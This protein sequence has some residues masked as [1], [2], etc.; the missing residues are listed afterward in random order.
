MREECNCGQ[1]P[2]YPGWL[3]IFRNIPFNPQPVKETAFLPSLTTD[4]RNEEAAVP[5]GSVEPPKEVCSNVSSNEQPSCS[6]ARPMVNS[7]ADSEPMFQPPAIINY[8]Q[9]TSLDTE[10]LQEFL[11][12]N[13]QYIVITN[14]PPD[15]LLRPNND[16]RRN[17]VQCI[18]SNNRRTLRCL[19]V[20]LN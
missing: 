10:Q 1:Y 20:S 19:P 7:A 14:K 8:M 16:D 13:G 11:G 15:D 5:S 2:H 3:S 4:N 6:T 18:S 9:V 17:S 12:Q